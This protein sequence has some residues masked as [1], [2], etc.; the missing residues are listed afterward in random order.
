M[1]LAEALVH[2]KEMMTRLNQLDGRLKNNA[3]YQEGSRTVEDP[4][5]LLAELSRCA[6]DLQNLI[7]R[8]NRTNALTVIDG[9]SL[10]DMLAER[11][12]RT[13]EARVMREFLN[14][15]SELSDRFS[16]NEIVMHSSVDVAELRR[17]ADEKSKAIRDL[18]LR[19]QEL[20]WKTELM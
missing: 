6:S 8:I 2:R 19:I 11:D 17:R 3:T 1:K 13:L 5:E 9:T 14:A 4:L 10:A 16:R 18:D 15:A 7:A 12:A 20:N